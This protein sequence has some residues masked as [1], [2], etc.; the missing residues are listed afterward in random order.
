M[1]AALWGN[2]ILDVDTRDTGAFVVLHGAHDI[3]FVAVSGIGVGHDRNIHGTRHAGRVGD[4]FG[5]G[6]QAEI[7]ISVRNGCAGAGHVDRR[8]ARLGDQHRG[9]SVVSS[10][11]DHHAWGTQ[12]R[13]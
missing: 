2:L 13:A 8:K 12:Q 7:G 1:A 11:R 3:E 9:Q 10:R 4:H 5:L 6:E